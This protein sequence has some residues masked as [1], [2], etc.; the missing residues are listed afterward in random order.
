MNYRKTMRRYDE[1][2]IKEIFTLFCFV[3]LDVDALNKLK[4]EN[5]ETRDVVKELKRNV[6]LLSHFL[7]DM[8]KESQIEV[9]NQEKKI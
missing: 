1:R 7:R 6:E 2:K 8:I 9:Q 4:I 3:E 5:S